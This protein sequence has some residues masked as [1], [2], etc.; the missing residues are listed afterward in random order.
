METEKDDLDA[1]LVQ[2]ASV[3]HV[4]TELN[5]HYID[6]PGNGCTYCGGDVGEVTKVLLLPKDNTRLTSVKTERSS[7]KRKQDSLE[8]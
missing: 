8:K 4:M 7:T 5:K 1:R 6:R 2:K 3:L